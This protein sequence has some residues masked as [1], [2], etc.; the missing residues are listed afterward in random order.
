MHNDLDP[1]M[2]AIEAERAQQGYTRTSFA[3]AAGLGHN[4]Y[5]YYVKGE[6]SP[7][8]HKLRLMCRTLNLDL[9]LLAPTTTE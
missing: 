9:H 8:L 3:R 6:A 2:Q 5:G 1:I 7:S 4:T